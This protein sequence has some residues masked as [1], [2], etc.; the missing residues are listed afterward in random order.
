M[1]ANFFPARFSRRELAHPDGNATRFRASVWREMDSGLQRHH[2]RRNGGHNPGPALLPLLCAD[3]SLL[4]S[5]SFWSY[6]LPVGSRLEIA[7]KE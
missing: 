7:L 1:K 5:R 4:T 2:D 6:E 3:F